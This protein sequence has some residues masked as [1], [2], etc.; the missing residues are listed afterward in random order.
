MIS[1]CGFVYFLY[2]IVTAQEAGVPI[3]V[4]V[5]HGLVEEVVIHFGHWIFLT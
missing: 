4:G 3:Y 2:Q 1:I 5:D